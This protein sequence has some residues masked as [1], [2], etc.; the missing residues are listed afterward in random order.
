MPKQIN[1]KLGFEADISQAKKQIAD[2]QNSLDNLMSS[3]IKD[4]AFTGYDQQIAEAQQ[5]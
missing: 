5:F 1:V 2:L 4:S 3:S